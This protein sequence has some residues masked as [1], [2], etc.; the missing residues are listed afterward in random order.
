MNKKV[1]YTAVTGGYDNIVKPKYIPD[2][3]DF[4]CFS[5]TDI[6]SDFWDIRKILP[7]YSDSTRTARKYKILPHRFLSEYDLS[8]W[9]DGNFLIRNDLNELIEKY[10]SDSNMACYDHNQCRLDP[11][12]CIYEE[13]KAILWLGQNDPNKKYKDIPKTVVEQ[14]NKYN[15]EG[16]PTGNGLIMSGVLL[17]KHNEIDVVKSMESWWEELKLHSRRDQLSFNYIAWKTELNFNLID[18]DIRDNDYFYLL[19]HNHQKR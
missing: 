9:V 17:R 8:I 10:L 3:F 18:G 6:Q 4:I 19:G 15:E 11:R 7:L 12:G 13:A 16:Y 14:V 2:G 1:I 5:D